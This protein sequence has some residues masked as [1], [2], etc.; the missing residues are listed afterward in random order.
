MS[1]RIAVDTKIFD[2][3]KS[4]APFDLEFERVVFSIF[5]SDVQRFEVFARG[6]ELLVAATTI[7]AGYIYCDSK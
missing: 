7:F 4:A 5:H 6:Q 1:P 3:E 2:S